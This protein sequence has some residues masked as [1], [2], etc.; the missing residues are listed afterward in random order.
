MKP[1]LNYLQQNKW[2]VI[3]FLTVGGLTAILYFSLF[4]FFFEFMT[5]AY[6]KAISISYIFALLFHFNANR[7][8]TF[9]GHGHSVLPHAIKYLCMIG[10]NY[11]VT[12][13]ITYIVVE[14]MHLSPYF[15]LVISIAVTMNIGYFLSRYWIYRKP[16]R[17]SFS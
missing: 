16:V 11:V 1:I 12:L 6:P 5:W 9:K 8:F 17:K 3:S 7:Y 2:S 14:N 4:S 15:G 13:G 10:L